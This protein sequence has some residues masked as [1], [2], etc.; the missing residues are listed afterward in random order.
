[1]L[2]GLSYAY[3]CKSRKQ[4]EGV[5]RLFIFSTFL[6]SGCVVLLTPTYPDTYTA[7]AIN[8]SL[9]VIVKNRSNEFTP[10]ERC[11]PILLRVLRKLDS[12]QETSAF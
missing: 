5:D 12:Q 8:A 2:K 7:F 11:L 10:G 3:I 4:F 1:M 9:A 6:R